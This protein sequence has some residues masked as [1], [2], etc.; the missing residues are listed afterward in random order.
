M[1]FGPPIARQAAAGRA[2]ERI[3]NPFCNVPLRLCTIHR[4]KFNSLGLVRRT[5]LSIPFR[6]KPEICHNILPD[7]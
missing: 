2:S 1:P 6:P 5:E 3:R 7:C 4:G